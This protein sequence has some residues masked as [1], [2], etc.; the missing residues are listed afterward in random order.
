MLNRMP[1][2]AIIVDIMD[3]VAEVQ[4]ATE[5]KRL[6]A[7]P[8]DHTKERFMAARRKFS[9][10]GRYADCKVFVPGADSPQA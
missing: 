6:K 4:A 3:E 9:I 1:Q 8:A 2:P 7:A 10:A 5:R